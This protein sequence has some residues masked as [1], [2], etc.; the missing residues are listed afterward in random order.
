M[1]R[2][3][4]VYVD[5]IGDERYTNEMYTYT[6]PRRDGKGCGLAMFTSMYVRLEVD[7]KPQRG[8]GG[9]Q[10]DKDITWV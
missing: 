1:G 9:G 2:N 3:Y 5:S 4:G 8:G 6:P 10:K 7:K